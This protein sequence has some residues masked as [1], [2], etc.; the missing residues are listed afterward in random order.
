MTPPT[1]SFCFAPLFNHP[2]HRDKS[3]VMHASYD[4]TGAFHPYMDAY[5]KLYG[6]AGKVATLKFNNHAPASDEFNAILTQIQH[7]VTAADAQLDAFIYFG[8]GWPTGLVS[9]DIYTNRLS[10][11]AKLIRANCVPGVTIVLYACLCGKRDTQGGCFAARL[12]LELSDMQATVFAHETAGHTTTNPYVYRFSGNKPP[13]AV[14][15]SGMFQ[16][17]YKLLKAECIDTKPRGNSAFWA[18]MPFM[19]DDEIRAEVG[20]Y[21]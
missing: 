20:N 1:N 10:E 9:A 21:R 12:A 6:T 19:T 15:P 8:H 18:R 17:F 11:L 3:G 7:A 5:A 14:A 4:A 2:G 13:E 16:S